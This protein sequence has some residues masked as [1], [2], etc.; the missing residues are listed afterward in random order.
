MLQ[1][2]GLATRHFSGEVAII[3]SSHFPCREVW[4]NDVFG[5]EGISV[6]EELETMKGILLSPISG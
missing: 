1:Y 4:P 5:H 2:H 6:D 3:V